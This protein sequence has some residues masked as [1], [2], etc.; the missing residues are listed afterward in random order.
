[1]GGIGY[2]IHT[3]PRKLD[4]VLSNQERFT[5]RMIVMEQRVEDLRTRVLKLELED[6]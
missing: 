6:E 2:L 5:Q 4:E 3:V 1:V